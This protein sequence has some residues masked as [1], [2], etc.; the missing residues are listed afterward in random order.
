VFR[1]YATNPPLYPA[2]QEYFRPARSPAGSRDTRIHTELFG[3]MP[4]ITPGSPTRT[5]GH[6]TNLLDLPDRAAGDLRAQR[7]LRSF[8]TSR[9]SVLEL[10]DACDIPTRWSCRS[11]VCHTCTTPLLA[12]DVTYSPSP[13]EPRR[14]RGL[15]CCAQPTTAIVLDL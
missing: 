3:A 6:L 10:A 5:A 13:L 11:G 14:R 2:V 7:H 8:A 9:H 12:G 15:I 1:D 4:S